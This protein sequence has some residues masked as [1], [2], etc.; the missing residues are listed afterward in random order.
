MLA[1]APA[2]AQAA[3]AA[4]V[5]PATAPWA[6][7]MRSL[8]GTWPAARQL[9]V[10]QLLL[11]HS[12]ALPPLQSLE[13]LEARHPYSLAAVSCAPAGLVHR[14]ERHGRWPWAPCD[15]LRPPLPRHLPVRAPGMLRARWSRPWSP[16]WASSRLA[17]GNPVSAGAWAAEGAVTRFEAEYCSSR[18]HSSWSEILISGSTPRGLCRR[19]WTGQMCPPTAV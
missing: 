10:G 1:L 3:L 19:Q 15:S 2:P 13:Q 6:W 14:A 17:S 7:S 8:A 9:E 16:Q 18:C 11:R 5:P 4:L 12:P